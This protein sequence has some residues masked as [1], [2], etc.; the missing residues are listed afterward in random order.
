M[1]VVF[2]R[3]REK[4]LAER[5]GLGRHR[6]IK[7]KD[8]GLQNG[9]AEARAKTV[10]THSEACRKIQA[11]YR[12]HIGRKLAAERREIWYA[13][14]DIQRV[15][16]GSRGRHIAYEKR[17]SAVRVVQTTYQ[18]KD[19]RLRSVA[20]EQVILLFSLAEHTLSPF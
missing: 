18:L 2:E 9:L 4:E 7:A 17:M 10:R 3:K 11:I 14:L 6:R 19:L 16:R 20:L 13:A 1:K 15:F 8:D 5:L 12:G